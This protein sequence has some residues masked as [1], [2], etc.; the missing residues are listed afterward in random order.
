[1][2]L[3]TLILK[4]TELI[5]ELNDE[6]GNIGVKHGTIIDA[7][8]MTAGLNA[9]SD[10]SIIMGGLFRRVKNFEYNE[11]CKMLMFV[12]KDEQIQPVREVINQVI[13]DISQSGTAVMFTMPIDFAEGLGDDN[14][15]EEQE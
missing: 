7:K 6:L 9:W 4:Q 1:M 5:S 3:L 10:D 13:G 11:E 12:L 15:L 14:I 2:K 8:S